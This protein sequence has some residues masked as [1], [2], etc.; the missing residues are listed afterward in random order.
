M[1]VF[2]S[3]ES[4]A[5]VS[6]DQLV[7]E[8]KK[9]ATVDELA[10]AYLN[11]E[12]FIGRLKDEKSGVLTDLERL[13]LEL[14]ATKR[15][16]REPAVQQPEHKPAAVEPEKIDLDARI[17]EALE[18]ADQQKTVTRNVQEVT[19]KLLDT[20]GDDV[21]ANEFVKAKARDLGVS[22]EFLQDAAAKSPKGFYSL[23]GLDSAPRQQASAAHSDVNAAALARHNAN[24]VNT[25]GTKAYFDKIRKEDPKRYWQADIQNAI[26]KAREAGTYVIT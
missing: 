12:Q 2:N 11:A 5:Q 3:D 26:F 15:T 22:V 20:F 16:E 24:D 25:P 10:K 13:Q 6:I 17:R 1:S 14:E 18:A 7:G 4:T 19:Q 8:G 21:K 9:Y 23:V